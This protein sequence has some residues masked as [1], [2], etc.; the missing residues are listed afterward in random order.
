MKGD[1]LSL[2]SAAKYESTSHSQICNNEQ[3]RRRNEQLAAED[4][5][6]QAA[7]APPPPYSSKYT[8]GVGYRAE[9]PVLI[10]RI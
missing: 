10:E 1:P 4:A 2:F 7:I 8:S 5:E 3:L 9:Y 6:L